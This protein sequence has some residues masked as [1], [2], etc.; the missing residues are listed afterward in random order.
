M[1]R[2]NYTVYAYSHRRVHQMA[3]SP[4]LNEVRTSIRVRGMSIRTEKTYIYWIRFF[5]RYNNCRHPC[6]MGAAEVVRFLGYP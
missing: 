5:I 6:E 3:S 2:P 1:K 4:F